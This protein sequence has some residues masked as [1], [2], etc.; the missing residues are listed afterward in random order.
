ML[1]VIDTM[2]NKTSQP[3]HFERKKIHGGTFSAP[4]TDEPVQEAILAQSTSE[5]VQEIE[6]ESKMAKYN[7]INVVLALAFFCAAV[8]PFGVNQ[9]PHRIRARDG[10]VVGDSSSSKTTTCLLMSDTWLESSSQRDPSIWEDI[11]KGIYST[12]KFSSEFEEAK[13]H[14][15]A[16]TLLR[17]GIPSLFFAASA[18]ISYPFVAIALANAIDDSGVFAVVSQDASQYIQ[19]ILTT[20]GLTFSILLGQTYYFMYQVRKNKIERNELYS[21]VKNVAKPLGT[22]LR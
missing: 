2:V 22:M 9:N 7:H 11:A 16:V 4:Q 15:T 13:A 10:V 21:I 6:E 1:C 18:K 8:K 3:D 20:S 17:V 14:A 19:N 5:G 12:S